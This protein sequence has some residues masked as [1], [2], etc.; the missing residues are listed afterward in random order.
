M[1]DYPM[2]PARFVESSCLKCHHQVTDL[3]S[4]N[5]RNEAPKVLKGYNLIRE[6]GCFGC[7]EIQGRKEGRPVGPD[8]RLEPVPPLDDL[9]AKERHAIKSD[10]DNLPGEYRKVG[11]SLYRLTEK[12][13]RDWALKWLKAPREFRPDTKM[14]HFYGLTNNDPKNLPAGQEKFPD[15][16]MHAITHYLFSASESY[17]KQVAELHPKDQKEYHSL[18]QSE[19]KLLESLLNNPT[20]V[21]KEMLQE[22]LSEDV[23]KIS[24]LSPSMIKESTTRLRSKIQKRKAHTPLVDLPADDK[25]DP[26]KGRQLFSERGCMACHS[27][28]ATETPQGKAPVGEGSPGTY[29]PAMM[30]E[31]QFGPNLSQLKAKLGKSAGHLPSARVWLRH[32]INN[33]HMH[34]PRSRMPI[35]HL[36]KEEVA[37]VA[38]WLLT[39][40]PSDLGKDWNSTA[41]AEPD[42]KDYEN[43]A[44][45]YLK[46]LLPAD[47]M[48]KFLKKEKLDENVIRDLPGDEQV[49]FKTK[50]ETEDLKFYLG[51]K[52]V[53]R[54]GCYGCHDV[55]GFESSKPIGTG[56]MDWGKKKSDKLAFEDV[57]RYIKEHYKAEPSLK[58]KDGKPLPALIDGKMP[59]EQ[60]FIDAV[61]AHQREGYLNQ[62]L[63]EPRSYDFNR[64]LAW[65]DRSRMPQFRFA[66]S[67]KK[68]GESD[69]DFEARMNVEEAEAREAVM[70]FVLGLVAEPVP[71]KSINQPKGDRLA[72]VKG[73]QVIDKYNCAGCHV[74]RPGVFDFKLTPEGKDL[75][76]ETYQ[77]GIA[78]WDDVHKFPKSYNWSGKNPDSPDRLTA[79]G[80]FNVKYN[81]KDDKIVD[82]PY[83]RL[84]HAL[85]F[86]SAE[87]GG[88]RDVP[89]SELIQ[90][91]VENMIYPP[92]SAFS[93]EETLT[94]FLRD[95][96]T[97]GGDF[98]NL[99]QKY[100]AEK[101]PSSRF[102]TLNSS[103]GESDNALSSGPP[104]L[105]GAGERIQTAWLTQF[106][107]EP[108]QF[109]KMTV[110]RMPKFNMS[111][112]EAEAL[113]KYFSAVSRTENTGTEVDF[114]ELIKQQ[115]SF[116]SKFWKEKNAAYIER[117]K[118]TP[119]P[120][121]KDKKSLFDLRKEEY[122]PYWEGKLDGRLE[123]SEKLLVAARK[124]LQDAMDDPANKKNDVFEKYVLP[125]LKNAVTAAEENKAGW[126]KE[127]SD[128]ERELKPLSTEKRKKYEEEQMTEWME[129]Y[130][131]VTDSFK[132]A[133][134][135]CAS[136]HQVGSIQASNP[137]A[138]PP[139][140]NL[141]QRLR[142]GW[143]ERWIAAPKRLVH[144][145]IMPS[146]F[147]PAASGY[148]ELFPGTS[149]EQVTSVRDVVLAYP[150]IEPL[151]LNR[152]WVLSLP[153]L[154]AEEEQRKAEAAKKKQ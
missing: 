65:D 151:A 77:K 57:A 114:I 92:A 43:L 69:A 12:T 90:V 150:R 81:A 35:T 107:L 21:P 10:M 13:N 3:Y 51:K 48:E 75:L 88:L 14:P 40:E 104:F 116:D 63:L 72:E 129:K 115:E 11:P 103:T 144:Y 80:F 18:L 124:S 17:L 118:N 79:Q 100:L 8:M 153:I 30:G 61:G 98:A 49:L 66:R 55:P 96:G 45:V 106:L 32:W 145:T 33:P 149:L 154:K 142:P 19:E 85:R 46:R 34:S 117:L 132:L 147:P 91:P 97:F 84:A 120:G 127:K 62:K 138:G 22:Y 41:I 26:L 135:V 71:V 56:L 29:A 20:A 126:E 146:N 136:C 130:A 128:L 82:K 64:N 102:G 140:A 67:H 6:N 58:D 113:V 27:H 4:P 83:L 112:D 59:Y 2:L 108:Y 38:E 16:E 101:G 74:I 36:T 137:A 148:Q 31:A 95:K 134:N 125:G 53:G 110:L 50:M 89:S 73:R 121:S 9:S 60:F 152:Y 109:R 93:S 94:R 25:G 7:H 78:S 37:D 131:Y 52:A 76:D 68:A 39:Q 70:T 141:H 105:I 143:T 87:T 111:H 86:P 23:S 122:R 1:W 123:A 44:R 24:A 139:L 42:P 99:L 119:V 28:H 54:L 15:A 47:Y 133:T 5:N